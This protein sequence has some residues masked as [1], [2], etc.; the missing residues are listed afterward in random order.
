MAERSFKSITV[1]DRLYEQIKER[2]K[3]ESKSTARFV[4][5]ILESF[6]YVKEKFSGVTPLLELISLDSKAVV[7]RDRKLDKVIGVRIKASGSGKVGLYCEL[8]KTE[9]CPHTAFAVALPQGLWPSSSLS[10]G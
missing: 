9:Y 7:V 6:L 5:E 4:S 8:D 10:K 1:A 2:A 3:K